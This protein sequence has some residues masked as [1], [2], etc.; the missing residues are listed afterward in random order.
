VY[1]AGYLNDDDIPDL[2]VRVTTP[3]KDYLDHRLILFLSD[4]KSETSL[5]RRSAETRAPECT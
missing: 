3:E 4:S 2:I 1:W 5:W